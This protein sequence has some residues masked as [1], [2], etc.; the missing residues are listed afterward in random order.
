MTRLCFVFTESKT[1]DYKRSLTGKRKVFFCQLLLLLHGFSGPKRQVR[2]SEGQSNAK[3]G[4][5]ANSTIK[6][7]DSL[8]TGRVKI[9]NE[10]QNKDFAEVVAH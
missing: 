9:E 5:E 1:T 2:R 4:I 6:P 3:E 8:E 10:H 7:G